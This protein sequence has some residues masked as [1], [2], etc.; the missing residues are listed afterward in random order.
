MTARGL[1]LIASLLLAAGARASNPACPGHVTHMKERLAACA[2][3]HGAHGEGDRDSHGGVYPRLA[4]QPP[5]YLRVQMHRFVAEQRTGIPPVAIMSR[6]LARL[7]DGYLDAISC[8]YAQQT[9]PYYP[10]AVTDPTLLATGARVVRDG[11][12]AAGVGAC[13]TCHGA[14]LDGH[15]PATPALA[16]QYAGYLRV[17]FA[18]WR[19]GARRDELHRRLATT[20]GPVRTRAVSLYLNSVAPP[21]VAAAPAKAGKP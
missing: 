20:L 18:H 11:V 21:G 3:C 8:W 14:A 16:G 13:T 10:P 2:L 17:Q 1:L 9:P 6:L 15:P 7:T 12:P 4:G 5:A 19:Q